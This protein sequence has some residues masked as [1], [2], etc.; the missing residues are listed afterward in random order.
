[1][2]ETTNLYSRVRP[3]LL[4]KTRIGMGWVGAAWLI[5]STRSDP[6]APGAIIIA[7]GVALRIWSSGYI[8]KLDHL[9][10]GGPYRWTRNPLYLGTY[11]MAVGTALLA[12]SPLLLLFTTVGFA[13]VYQ[14]VIDDEEVKLKNALGQDYFRYLGKVPRFF[15]LIGRLSEKEALDLSR[16]NAAALKFDAPLAMKNKAY[17]AV[18]AGVALVGFVYLVHLFWL[19]AELQN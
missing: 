13:I 10:V 6:W 17:E 14:F 5:L 19:M 4:G 16:N 12:R 11:L 18:L 7:L 2:S 9:A 8:R 3:H 15:P 1:M